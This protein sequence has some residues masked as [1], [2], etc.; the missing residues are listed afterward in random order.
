MTADFHGRGHMEQAMGA[1]KGIK[2]GPTQH[3]IGRNRRTARTP[4]ERTINGQEHDLPVV[5]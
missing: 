3:G 5:R 4:S 2:C 1:A